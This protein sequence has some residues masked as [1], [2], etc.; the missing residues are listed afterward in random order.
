MSAPVIPFHNLTDAARRRFD[1]LKGSMMTI[2]KAL[3]SRRKLRPVC[4]DLSCELKEGGIDLSAERLRK[5]YYE[6]Q[7]KGDRVL[8]DLRLCGGSLSTRTKGRTR[9]PARVL[10]LWHADCQRR[11]DKAPE[12]AAW[13]WLMD[14]LHAGKTIEGL[15][16]WETLW[17]QLH[18]HDETPLHCPWNH[19]RPPP[20]W[21]L[22]NFRRQV[23]PSK[24]SQALATDGVG[25]GKALLAKH[26]GV[27]IDW[28][29][30]RLMEVVYFD[31]HDLDFGCIVDGQI[32]RL[33]LLLAR[34]AR[35]R[36][37]LAYGVRPRL[38]GEDGVR[39]SVTRR[40]MQHLI[41]GLLY[42]FGLPRDYPVRLVVE[43]AAAAVATEFEPVLLRATGG[44]VTVERTGLYEQMV[45]LGG[46]LEK[47]GSPTGKAMHESGFK[48]LDIQLAKVRGQMGSNYTVKPDEYDP[49]IRATQ[50]LLNSPNAESL[51]AA[52][53][54]GI[55]LPFCNLWEAHAE[56]NEALRVIDYRTSH[57]LEG[58]LD[59]TEFRFSDGDAVYRPVN[60]ELF[61]FQSSDIKADIKAFSELPEGL[62]NRFLAY[63]RSRK[64]SPAECWQR[65]AC[66]T[67]F[68]KLSDLSLFEM[69]MDTSKPREYAGVNT[70]KIELRGQVIEYR[71]HDHE[72]QPG[73]K[74]TARYNAD[75]PLQIWLQDQAGRCVGT[76][77]RSERLH[78]HDTEG[79]KAAMEFQAVQMSYAIRE[80]RTLQMAHPAALA[81]LRDR[82]AS[83]HLLN[84]ST[85]A[86]QAP[87]GEVETSSDLG[88]A[89]ATKHRAKKPKTETSASRYAALQTLLQKD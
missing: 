2:E 23:G 83:L 32:V 14:E 36:R 81:E 54:S 58:F 37:V 43:N 49:R 62:Q 77:E 13:R 33:R 15:G 56:L 78:Y 86:I 27:R 30:L 89:V 66:K 59:V 50:K 64:E 82:E 26:A 8:I 39:Q 47:G 9:I 6:W 35:T 24:I 61:P 60:V 28:T 10:Q 72:L 70:F 76:M 41:A 51:L 45:R 44:R 67:P 53:A 48:L 7:Q 25:A 17:L 29:S 1:L 88:L 85:E 20:G 68:L 55:R 75:H 63:G 21:T 38:V 22:S 52:D 46:Y 42:T 71:G 16:T 79:R 57:K 65:L 19:H 3:R 80:T 12:A 5:R 34:D 40:D 18:P 73:E 31:D 87:V 84:P 11:A 69:M 4:A 74:Y